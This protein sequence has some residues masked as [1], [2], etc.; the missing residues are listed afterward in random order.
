M[1]SISRKLSAALAILTLAALLNAGPVFSSDTGEFETGVRLY[2]QHEYEK[3]LAYFEKAG[4]ATAAAGQE[5]PAILYYQANALAKLRRLPEAGEIYH[6][7][8]QIAPE[9]RAGRLSKIALNRL[10]SQLKGNTVRYDT[11]TTYDPNTQLVALQEKM[12]E[13]M[14]A[15][16]QSERGHYLEHIAM[17]QFVAHWYPEDM[18]IRVHVQKSSRATRYYDLVPRALDQWVNAAGGGLS[19]VMV[20]SSEEAHIRIEWVNALGPAMQPYQQ[21][22]T[23]GLTYVQGIGDRLV[24]HRMEMATF[25]RLTQRPYPPEVIYA[26]LIHEF[27]HA[28][29]MVGHS[30]SPYDIMYP[31]TNNLTTLS[32]RDRTT[33][34]AIYGRRN[35]AQK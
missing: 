23:V 7:I 11:S 30:P 15:A 18:P 16:G 21:G 9:T 35:Q 32:V 12:T 28:L 5:N 2:Q 19:Y 29:G 14:I 33:I 8:T 4:A 20:E 25:D 26:T 10:N 34:R 13:K 3:A 24:P 1:A 22:H 6:H 27:G 17:G 31:Y